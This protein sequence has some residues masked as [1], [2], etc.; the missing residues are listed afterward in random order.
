[1]PIYL[2]CLQLT[3][4]LR[5][6][7]LFTTTALL[8]AFASQSQTKGLIVKSASVAG[9]AVLD[10][11]GD[12]YV[13]ATTAGFSANDI[14]ESEIPFKALTV[15]GIEPNSDLANGPSCGFTDFVDAPG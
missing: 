1:M 12:G 14:A 4:H 10:A 13:S 15:P 2:N 11:N 7:L 9:R 8:L 6:I 3:S 5:K